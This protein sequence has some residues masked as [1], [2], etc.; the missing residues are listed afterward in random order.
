MELRV[1]YARCAGLEVGH[2][3]VV[4]GNVIPAWAEGKVEI[5]G[6]AEPEDDGEDKTLV[7]NPENGGQPV[8]QGAPLGDGAAAGPDA[9]SLTSPVAAPAQAPAPAQAAK[10]K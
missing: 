7:V 6:D 5:I 1:K 10:A 4:K 2:V 9:A 8:A 3:F